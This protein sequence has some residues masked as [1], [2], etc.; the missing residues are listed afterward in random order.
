MRNGEPAKAA[1]AGAGLAGKWTNGSPE[2]PLY[3][4]YRE[5][6]SAYRFDVPDGRYE[7]RLRFADPQMTSPGKRVFTVKLGNMV[8]KE[9]LD[10]VAVAGASS[11]HDVV[12]ITEVADGQGLLVT[13]DASIGLPVVSGIDVRKL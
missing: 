4:T 5:G 1:G 2:D 13:F 6:M 10:L 7:V 12:G 3:Q 8:L 11:A 9:N